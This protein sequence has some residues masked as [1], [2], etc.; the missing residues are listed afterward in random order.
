M[1]EKGVKTTMNKCD[2][3]SMYQDHSEKICKGI[4]W[5]ILLFILLIFFNSNISIDQIY[6]DT[7]KE[8]SKDKLSKELN[9]E[10]EVL[11][12][13][14]SFKTEREVSEGNNNSMMLKD[15]FQGSKRLEE[16]VQKT[17]RLD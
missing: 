8:E 1:T 10:K 2:T 14:Q 9:K 4:R 11:A 12:K 15:I 7:V 16:R 3:K 5:S 13:N 17:T 6:E